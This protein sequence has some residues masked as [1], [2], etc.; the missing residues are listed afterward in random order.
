MT[1]TIVEPLP[2]DTD[3]AV[4]RAQTP[5]LGGRTHSEATCTCGD[6]IGITTFDP[7]VGAEYVA[8]W[9]ASHLSSTPARQLLR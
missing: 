3:H 9:Q 5:T 7:S 4:T 6:G 1:A 2:L 8:G